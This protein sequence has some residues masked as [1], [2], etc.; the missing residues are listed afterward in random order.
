[1]ANELLTSTDI[2]RESL[3]LLHAKLGFI[4]SIPKKHSKEF[5]KTGA[6][7]GDTVEVRLPNQYTIRTGRMF[8]PQEMIERTKEIKLNNQIGVDLKFSSTD[9]TLSL[10]KFSERYLYPAM[11]VL[12]SW[13]ETEV[14]RLTRRVPS[15]ALVNTLTLR[16]I[17]EAKDW[18]DAQFAPPGK[19]HVQMA[20]SHEGH[21]KREMR[22]RY[23]PKK[24]ISR[25]YR[26]REITRISG[27]NP[28]VSTLI[29]EQE[30]IPINEKIK[31]R[32]SLRLLDVGAED[33]KTTGY[34]Q[35]KRVFPQVLKEGET[36]SFDKCMAVHP[37]TRQSM[38]TLQRFVVTKVDWESK[39]IKYT[40]W[41]GIIK[42]P[43]YQNVMFTDDLD[44][45]KAMNVN[46]M[47]YPNPDP[48]SVKNNAK[49]HY[50]QS[51]F[52]QPEAFCFVTADLP[53][54]DGVDFSAR[55]EVD[56]IS[57]RVV[58]DYDEDEDDMITRVDVLFG[59]EA[60]IP[61]FACRIIS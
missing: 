31:G 33:Q 18:L 20:L 7:V 53:M 54:P 27:F 47:G 26:E 21:I 38:G 23:N 35:A 15:I 57:M 52:Y 2:A 40:F 41:P 37:E 45:S 61:N 3:R 55:E 5:A 22:E 34:N 30:V 17:L 19:R 4:R 39:S 24:V 14:F 43:P 10:D 44:F 1:M 9:L 32:Q 51:L 49:A 50:D 36:F 11:S 12:A 28:F 13:I 16:N 60:L 6:K 29:P 56:G 42:E 46:F 59:F 25:I 8:N 58:R 48:D